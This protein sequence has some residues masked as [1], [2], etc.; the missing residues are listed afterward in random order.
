MDLQL[1]LNTA[2]R[3]ALKISETEDNLLM[4]TQ[5]FQ[6]QTCLEI[7]FRSIPFSFQLQISAEWFAFLL[8]ISGRF[9]KAR[10]PFQS[11]I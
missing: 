4:Y 10:D 8:P 11:R 9:S 7:P 5:I 2:K 6:K 1:P 3:L